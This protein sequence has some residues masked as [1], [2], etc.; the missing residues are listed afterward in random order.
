MENGVRETPKKSASASRENPTEECRFGRTKLVIRYGRVGY[1]STEN[2]FK[3]R[4]GKS[5]ATNQNFEVSRTKLRASY[6]LSS[7]SMWQNQINYPIEFASHAVG[8]WGTRIVS[9]SG[10]NRW[11]KTTGQTPRRATRRPPKRSEVW[12]KGSVPTRQAD[13]RGSFPL[14]SH[15]IDAP[16]LKL[17]SDQAEPRNRWLLV[18]RKRTWPMLTRIWMSKASWTSLPLRSKL[19]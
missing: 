18:R 13:S 7:V 12:M 2:I 19:L 4:R 15:Q 1:I 17:L 16:P 3:S 5:T 11:K 10:W 9:T 6:A 14:Q 8:I